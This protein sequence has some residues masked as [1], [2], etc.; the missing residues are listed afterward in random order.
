MNRSN[1]RKVLRYVPVIVLVFFILM[2]TVV[3]FGPRTLYGEVD[4]SVSLNQECL[5]FP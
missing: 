3:V 4:D 2:Y 1:L 5:H